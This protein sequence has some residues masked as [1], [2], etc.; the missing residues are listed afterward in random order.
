MAVVLKVGDVEWR[1][2]WV[3]SCEN[4]ESWLENGLECKVS[5]AFR[6]GKWTEGRRLGR[7]RNGN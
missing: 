7:E 4:S 2:E 5:C 1:F 3:I 6:S